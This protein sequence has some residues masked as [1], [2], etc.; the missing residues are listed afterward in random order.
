MDRVMRNN[1][2]GIE[3]LAGLLEQPRF[4]VLP[5]AGTADRVAGHLP[6]GRMVTITA[7]PSRG[8]DPTID[9]SVELAG[10]GYE[11]VP[12]LAARMV[13][14]AGHLAEIVHR[15]REAGIS[16]VFV[17]SGDAE[18]A[19]EYADAVALLRALGELGSPFAHVGITGYPES[20]PVIPD[21]LTV[22]AMWDKRRHATELV[23]NLT[24]DP[25]VVEQWLARVRRRGVTLPLWLGVP[26]PTETT[27]LLAVAARIGVGES[28]RYLLKHR[29]AMT[30]LLR[31]GGFTT[32][33]FL[34]RL[35]PTLARPESVVAGLHVF[36]FNQVAE[37]EAW[38]E[39]LLRQLRE[40]GVNT[41]RPRRGDPPLAS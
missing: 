23:S 38:R 24:F 27:R 35:A 6:P 31:P 12:H 36:T 40:G 26:G 10:L 9:L 3:A 14:D 17:P 30:R 28:T 33:A 13:T 5:T 4:E 29:R 20:H 41:R 16:R 1:S 7:S 2:N 15:L 8:L 11:A 34:R 39:R 19:G 25:R 32:D 37:A 21:D 18:Q 22:Q